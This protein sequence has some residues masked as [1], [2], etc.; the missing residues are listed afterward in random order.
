MSVHM[1]VHV[2]EDVMVHLS[3]IILILDAT[4]V[5]DTASSREVIQYGQSQGQLVRLAGPTKSYVIC[6]DKI[7]ASPTSSLTLLRRSK[8][9][10]VV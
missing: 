3:D 10:E 4:E 5:D 8:P 6:H 7:Y 2:G 9:G 1:W